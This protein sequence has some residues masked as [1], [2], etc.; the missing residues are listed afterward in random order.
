MGGRP[1]RGRLVGRRPALHVPV[2]VLTH[3]ARETVEK[4]GGTSFT[5]VTDGLEA[6][7]E[8]A[9]A[10]AGDRDVH[11]AG[12]ASAIQQCLNA[13]LLDELQVHVVPVLLGGGTPLFD[14][15]DEPFELEATR[16]I[17]SPAVTHLRLAIRERR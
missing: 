1:E 15:L 10:A 14:G 7:L 13:G 9:R 4:K 6:A 16:V 5:F 11:V 17:C 3:H 12:G 8:Q 2:F